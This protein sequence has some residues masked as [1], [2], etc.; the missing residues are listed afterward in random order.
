MTAMTPDPAPDLWHHYGRAR[1][2]RDREVPG[3]FRWAWDQVSGPGA[4]VLGELAGR[5]VG[6]LG[7]GAGR[8]AAY[9]AVRHGV[10]R[11]DA[12]DGSAA[13]CGMAEGLFG[14]LAPRLRVVRADAVAHVRA[15][16]GAYDVLY[17][18]FGAV[19]FSEPG[20]LLPAAFGALRPG[21]RLVF[22]TLAECVD[23][24]PARG[25]VAAV[26]VGARTAAG[27]A[28]VM[29]RWVLRGEVWERALREAGFTGVEV[30]TLAGEARTP[31]ALLVT[32]YR[33][34]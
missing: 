15:A 26:E 3:A 28:A 17:S 32:A 8:Q 24:A 18:L 14:H 4:E 11:V 9:L 34:A 21:G 7:A 1:A 16:P 6:D 22:A 12:V 25:E 23:G 5:V 19:C 33:P 13:Q 27:E 29:R 10:A 2:E 31:G 20:E 30:E